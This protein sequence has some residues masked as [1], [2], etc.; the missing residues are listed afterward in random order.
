MSRSAW[1]LVALC[2]LLALSGASLVSSTAE[3]SGLVVAALALAKAALIGAVFLEL[4]HAW[5][6]WALGF[7]ALVMAILGGSL[8][9]LP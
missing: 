3:D 5:P 9:L 6:G 4:D 8:L 1:S 7:L 2:V